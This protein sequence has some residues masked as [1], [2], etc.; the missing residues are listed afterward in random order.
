[1]AEKTRELESL[2]I[3][4]FCQDMAMMLHAG[5]IP[6]EAL[7]LLAEDTKEGTFYEVLK[8]MEKSMILGSSFAEAVKDSSAFPVYAA[9]MIAAG[10]KAGRLDQVLQSL[11]GYY[12]RQDHLSRQIRSAIIYPLSLLIMMSAVLLL[13]VTIVLPVFVNVYEN[14]AGSLAQSSYIYISAARVISIISLVVTGIISIVILVLFLMSR[15]PSGRSA[16]VALLQKFPL[17]KEAMRQLSVSQFT[18]VISTFLSSG[19]DTDTAMEEAVSLVSHPELKATLEKASEEMQAGK[20]LAQ[21]LY[22]H[23]IY[24]PLYGRMLLSAHRS[25]QMEDMLR[26]LSDVT[27]MDAESQIQQL[28]SSIEPIMTGFLTVSVG[29]TLLSIML[30]LAGM[31]SA[32]G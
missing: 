7:G 20:S 15:T 2:A 8:S 25:G 27:G 19:M 13:M 9:D 30:P 21:A 28:I 10:E 29:L 32:I 14:M 5:I 4:V 12:E 22:D 24:P 23:G 31:L 1:M 18:D 6:E 16:V 26:K 11:S 17:T 3:S